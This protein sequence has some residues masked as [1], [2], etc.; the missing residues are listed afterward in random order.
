MIILEQKDGCLLII[1]K[2]VWIVKFIN[3]IMLR[4]RVS[5]AAYKMYTHRSIKYCVL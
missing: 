4:V 3:M 1:V 5:R 2:D